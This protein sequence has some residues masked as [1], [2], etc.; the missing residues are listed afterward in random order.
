M[1]KDN[2]PRQGASAVLILRLLQE[3]PMYGY[4]IA[5]ELVKRSEGYFDFKEGSL[6]P[7]LHKLEREGL[8]RGE[9][10]VVEQGPSRKYY[11]LTDKGQRA[12]KESAKEWLAFSER[13]AQFLGHN[14][15]QPAAG[16]VS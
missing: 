2:D 6:Y 8:I 10:Q 12:L 4:L 14:E 13:L 7:A 3:R 9:W 15:P 16:G 11:H 1:G 5:K